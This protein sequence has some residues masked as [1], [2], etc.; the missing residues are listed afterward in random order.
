VNA[1]APELAH[2]LSALGV[3]SDAHALLVVPKGYADLRACHTSL[4]GVQADCLVLWKATLVERRGYGRDKNPTRSPY[5]YRLDLVWR[6][7]DGL[8]RGAVFGDVQPWMALEDEE[9][10]TFLARARRFG[11][12]WSFSGLCLAQPI[13]R[14][15]A[16]YPGFPPRTSSAAVTA[17]VARATRDAQAVRDASALIRAES[18]IA[19]ALASAGYT[20]PAA[21]LRALHMPMTPAE[22]LHARDAARRAAVAQ[23]QRC[24]ARLPPPDVLAAPIPIDDELRRLVPA[25]RERLSE[26]QRNAL[27]VIRKMI[28][29]EHAA[30]ILLN[31]DVGTG[32]TLVFLLAAAAVAEGGHRVAVMVPNELVARQIHGQAVARFPGLRPG[33]VTGSSG[34]LD[35]DSLMLIGTQALLHRQLGGLRLLVIDEQHKFSV[36]QRSRLASE[37]THVIEA[38]ATPIPRSVALALFDGWTQ[39]KVT[40]SHTSKRIACHLWT[41]TDRGRAVAIVRRHVETGA[42]VVFLYPRLA[43]GAKAKQ[44]VETAAEALEA[45]YAGKVVALHGKLSAPEKEQALARFKSGERPLL[46]ATTIMEVGVDVPDIRC[47]VVSNAE[48]FGVAQLHQLRGRLARSGGEADFV[49]LSTDSINKDARERLA[50]IRD[51]QD[52]FALAEFDV[53]I[54]G[55]GD[56]LGE[57]QSGSTTTLFKGLELAPEDFLPAERS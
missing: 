34:D 2:P 9:A 14:V 41:D 13:G 7:A 57:V 3:T 51:T 29:R 20:T 27:N 18:A 52:G 36:E 5:P 42:K 10:V 33:L 22:G 24:A 21:F 45:R 56:V 44:S 47:M 46:V 50:A 6:L 54:R 19:T 23:I 43:A 16:R 31:G 17:V 25:Q 40:G 4:R 26:G 15:E 28:K 37:R 11:D 12:Q 53:R 30:R 38:S 49:M 35:E 39:A 55:F 32:K 48:R 1:R 8:V